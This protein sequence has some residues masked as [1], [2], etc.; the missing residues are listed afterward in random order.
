M[1]VLHD[2]LKKRLPPGMSIPSALCQL[3]SWI[4]DNGHYEDIDTGRI[5]CLFPD[6]EMRAGRTD[7][8]RPGGTNIDFFAYGDNS[9]K[10]WFRHDR[11]E[12]L[13]RLCQFARTGAEGSMGLL[14]LDDDGNQKIVHLGSG[15]GSTMSCVLADDPVDFLRL[16]AIGYDEI[17]WDSE[18]SKP[19]NAGGDYIVRPNQEFQRWVRKTFSV[20]IPRTAM[21]IVKHPHDTP[22]SIDPFY[23]WVMH[24]IS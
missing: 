20:S 24:N 1:S 10:S 17:C 21:K 11:P 7:T 15:S 19:P 23:R 12:V 8:E 14:W 6:D 9:L 4:E 3:Y 16:I 13:N 5:G 22:D 18:F 2:Q